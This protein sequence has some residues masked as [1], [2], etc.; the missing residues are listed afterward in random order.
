MG[1]LENIQ[2]IS[3]YII[4]TG[5]HKR[6]SHKEGSPNTEKATSNS[7]GLPAD[8]FCQSS[9]S[10]LEK[11]AR[12]GSSKRKSIQTNRKSSSIPNEL[13]HSRSRAIPISKASK[14]TILFHKTKFESESDADGTTY[15]TGTTQSNA[16]QQQPP[17]SKRRSYAM[18]SSQANLPS[19]LRPVA[20]LPVQIEKAKKG[21]KNVILISDSDEEMPSAQEIVNDESA[22]E[23][24]SGTT[25]PEPLDFLENRFAGKTATHPNHDTSTN[26]KAVKPIIYINPET[27]MNDIRR[28]NWKVPEV[29]IPIYS[30]PTTQPPNT[31]KYKKQV[32][33]EIDSVHSSNA[34]RKRKASDSTN[35]LNGSSASKQRVKAPIQSQGNLASRV[36]P[37]VSTPVP[38]ITVPERV[39]QQQHFDKGATTLTDETQH[40]SEINSTGILS[41]NPCPESSEKDYDEP[42]FPNTLELDPSLQLQF[43]DYPIRSYNYVQDKRKCTTPQMLDTTQL[44][45]RQT[46]LFLNSYIR[47][48]QQQLDCLH[49]PKAHIERPYISLEV[50]S[51]LATLNLPLQIGD[52]IHHPFTQQ[53]KETL[54]ANIGLGWNKIS[55]LLPGRK[56]SDCKRFHGDWKKSSSRDELMEPLIFLETIDRSRCKKETKPK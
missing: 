29:V 49:E 50:R 46:L 1:I 40:R 24:R 34:L 42:L 26:I 17:K 20:P 38:Y 55:K 12:S 53:E 31:P 35:H 5:L 6:I 32:I 33:I 36:K 9:E 28:N 4:A 52:I 10:S 3:N 48:C 22:G 39:S 37:P 43:T 41:N 13:N 21:T 56:P 25:T 51:K 18:K 15:N 7:L 14:S 19:E 23:I 54:L 30:K 27:G 8:N 11:N 16:Y 44:N 45:D 47:I 2:R